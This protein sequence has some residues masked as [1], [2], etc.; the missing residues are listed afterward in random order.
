MTAKCFEDLVVWQK[1]HAWVLRA[2]QL[3]RLF[4]DTELFGLTSQLR[5]AAVSVPANIA[6]GFKR[7]GKADKLRFYNTAQSS[8]EECRYYLIL[9]RDLGYA[10][11][12][13]EMRQ[14]NEVSRLL[15]SYMSAIRASRW[16]GRYSPVYWILASGFWLLS[17]SHG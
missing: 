5:R 16:G 12:D 4:P 2:Y 1:T 11:T 13:Q 7:T 9:A 17:S 15:E 3:V 14:L 10:D 8:L 6:E